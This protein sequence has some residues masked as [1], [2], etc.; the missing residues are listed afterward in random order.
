MNHSE[1]L[2]LNFNAPSGNRF[3]NCM[4]HGIFT[5]LFEHPAP[6]PELPDDEAAA[7]LAALE[8]AASGIRE[9][10]CALALTD[11]RHRNGGRRAVDSAASRSA[12]PS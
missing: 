8:A 2:E 3:R 5:V 6:G 7:R 1:Q 12:S 10:P 11:V 4:A 9:L